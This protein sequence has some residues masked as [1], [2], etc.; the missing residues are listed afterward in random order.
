MAQVFI[1]KRWRD[2]KMVN[3]VRTVIEKGKFLIKVGVAG[4]VFVVRC[5]SNGFGKVM[6]IY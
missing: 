6:K 3:E 1:Q 2:L 4:E 5:F